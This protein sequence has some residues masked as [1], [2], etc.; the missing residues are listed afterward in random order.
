MIDLG[1]T[2]ITV[3]LGGS[4]ILR[5]VTFCAQPGTVT[6]IIGPNGAGKSTLV[7]ALAGDL[8]PVEGSVQID[9][10]DVHS[11]PKH[12]LARLRAVLPQHHHV[13]FGFTSE[14]VV[15]MGCTNPAD[16]PRKKVESA[17]ERTDV[18][19]LR[20][21]R[22]RSLSGGEQARVAMA[23]I[24]AQDTPVLLLD[25]PTA[26]LDLRH[27]ELVMQ[28]ARAEAEA[29]RTVVVVVHDLNLGAAYTDR[30]L[31]LK[32]GRVLADDTTRNVLVPEQIGSAY[33]IEV[34]VVD[35]PTRKC[36]LIVTVPG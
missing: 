19:H 26:S 4:E 1:A 10:R 3:V 34:A 16:D 18:T 13:S 36:P 23:R 15:H 27:Q 33:D 11:I 25:E 30:M 35:H 29:G 28:L 2:E 14:E 8:A 22:F 12:R 9:G 6:G 24:L 32:D 20:H 21:R 17:M 7:A 5:Q 31:L